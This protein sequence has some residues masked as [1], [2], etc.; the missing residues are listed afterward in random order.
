MDTVSRRRRSKIM[1]AIPRERTSIEN[2]IYARIG[3]MGFVVKRND[4]TLP[5]SPDLLITGRGTPTSVP[6]GLSHIRF[7]IPGLAVF[8]HGCYWHACPLHGTL[9]KSNVA[10]WKRKFANNKARDAENVRALRSMGFKV[11]VVWEHERPEA[12][13]ERIAKA[14]NAY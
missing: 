3:S 14:W 4:A 6:A 12:A 11:L 1:R 10:F 5:G 13:A 9:P 8:V 7:M 2:A